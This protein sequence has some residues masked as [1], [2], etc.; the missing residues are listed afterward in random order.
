MP[1]QIEILQRVLRNARNVETRHDEI[2]ITPMQQVE[3]AERNVPV[4]HL[5][6]RALILAA[7]GVR[8]SEPIDH[9]AERLE[10]LLG[11]A[12]NA[13]GPINQ[14]AEDITQ[15]RFELLG[16]INH[17]VNGLPF[18]RTMTLVAWPFIST[19]NLSGVAS[20]IGN[21]P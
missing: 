3:L 8:K 7:P 20:M 17:T 13:G 12:G 21:E 19:T 9:D 14:G 2:E 5:V 16:H 11:L 6:H 4:A 1:G 18:S 10:N 15:Q